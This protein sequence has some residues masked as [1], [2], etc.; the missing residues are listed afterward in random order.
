MN[1]EKNLKDNLQNFLGYPCNTAY[2]YSKITN[3]FNT[4]INN[5][6][7]PYSSSTYKANTKNI[8]I[9]V[10]NYFAELWGIN[11]NNIWGYISNGGTEANLQGLYVG[12]ENLNDNAIFYTS[13][14]SHY[15][16]F[17]IAKL[18]KL[19]LCI[20]KSL[21]NGE[22]DYHDLDH[23]IHINSDKPILININIG[24]TMKGAIDN[25][26]EIMRIIKKYN[27]ENDYY[28]HADAALMG[29]IL[30]FI[31]KDTFF[32]KHIHSISISGHKFLGIPF[33][34]GVF[35]M[36]KKFKNN[37]TKN[38]EY[39]GSNDSMISGSRN[40]HSPIF[41]KHII[42][43][44]TKDDFKQDI[45]K[46]I[47]LAEYLVNNI[48]DAWRNQN[49]ITVVI[50]KPSQELIDK[51]QLATN[52]DISHVVVMPHVTKEKLDKFITDYNN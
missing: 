4:H 21:D 27:K 19:N 2:D 40:G 22:I 8:E 47:E 34:C 13:Q 42:T 24:T 46:C 31:E 3:L 26:S 35:L 20:I 15:S 52:N 12:R 44:K 7:C 39:I 18:L 41:F 51:W 50:P 9:D 37:I 6:G 1:L 33:P 5:V 29:F 14:D 30:P 17:K 43:T 16:I 25:P 28:M 23:N 45:D 32:K 10:L 49:S 38:I 48:K 36:E 11:T